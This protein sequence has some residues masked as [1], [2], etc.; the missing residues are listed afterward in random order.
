ME[1]Y[2]LYL[3]HVYSLGRSDLVVGLWSPI[4]HE[5]SCVPTAGLPRLLPGINSGNVPSPYFSVTAVITTTRDSPSDFSEYRYQQVYSGTFAAPGIKIGS[6]TA[7]FLALVAFLH[8]KAPVT[9]TRFK[10][11]PDS[12][13]T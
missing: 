5:N 10:D 7:P 11:I 4:I 8:T 13:T 1:Q 2:S 12:L 3:L 9:G 6:E